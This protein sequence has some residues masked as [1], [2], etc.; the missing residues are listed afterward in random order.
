MVNQKLF[1]AA[2]ARRGIAQYQLAN[3]IKMSK[4]TMSAKV[5]GRSCFDTDQI[6]LMCEELGIVDANEKVDIFLPKS[7]LKRDNNAS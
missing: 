5:N 4:N 2:L 3:K 1:R 6:D 7:S